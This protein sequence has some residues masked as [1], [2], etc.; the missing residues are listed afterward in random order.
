[1]TDF[2]MTREMKRRVV[3]VAIAAIHSDSEEANL[4]KVD[5]CPGR[6]TGAYASTLEIQMAMHTQFTSSVMV[7]GVMG[8][9]VHNMH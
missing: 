4:L 8:N 5:S 2:S 7:T 3:L 9:D 1:M 6:K